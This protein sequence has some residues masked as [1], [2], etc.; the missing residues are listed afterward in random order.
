MQYGVKAANF[1][2]IPEDFERGALPQTLQ[3]Y[4]G[5]LFGLSIHPER[6]AE[7]R[8]ERRPNST[9]ASL[10][11]CRQEVADA[12]RLIVILHRARSPCNWFSAL[13]AAATGETHGG[14][15]NGRSPNIAPR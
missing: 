8:N 7:V 12:E 10:Q 5:K 11:Q 14:F 1:P 15:G 6:L 2:L 9:Y 13:H 3:P 4:R